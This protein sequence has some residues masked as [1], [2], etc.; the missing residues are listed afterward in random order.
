MKTRKTFFSLVLIL[1]GFQ[2]LAQDNLLKSLNDSMSATSNNGFV[3]GTFKA[4]Y[5]VNMKTIEAPAAGAL[6]VEIQHRFGTINTGAYNLWGL[7]FATLRLGLDYGITDRFS[8]GIGRSS[9]LETFDGYLKYKLLRQSE[10]SMPV[11]VGLLGTSS[12][13]TNHAPL[14]DNANISSSSRFN[15]TLQMLIARKFNSHFSF[16]LTPTF[17]HY[18]MVTSPD[19]NNVFALC[20]GARMKISKRMALTAEY[21]YLFPNQLVSPLFPPYPPRTNSLSLGWDIETGGHVFQLVMTNS[22]S[23]VESQ[24]IGSTAGTWG[25]GYIY[26]GFNISRNF[27]LKPHNKPKA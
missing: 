9:Y 26:F 27:N 20:G 7:D 11:S 13:F 23:M 8:V 15:Y 2:L 4:L 12:Y 18:N 19:Q 3:T 14:G 22:Q 25:K 17:I 24:Y 21:D 1:S 10:N 5:I 6:N 16:E